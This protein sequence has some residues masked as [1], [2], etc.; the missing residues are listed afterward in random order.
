MK[1]FLGKQHSPHR[2]LDGKNT[3]Y[4]Y[5][6][7]IK[8]K[9]LFISQA[10]CSL[11]FQMQKISFQSSSTC[12]KQNCLKVTQQSRLFAL[13]PLVFTFFAGADPGIFYPGGPHFDSERT[14][15]LFLWQITSRP[16]PPPTLS[17]DHRR[18]PKTIIITFFINIPRI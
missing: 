11:L 16:H 3:A 7:V 1:T 13:S 12:R 10:L 14:A 8:V 4:L 5:F 18:V 2:H 17:S 6:K 15:E 9:M